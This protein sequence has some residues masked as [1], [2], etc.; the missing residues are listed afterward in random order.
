M[1]LCIC[2]I[3]DNYGVVRPKCAAP[4]KNKASPCGGKLSATPTDEGIRASG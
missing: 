4:T 2:M 3:I 1:L